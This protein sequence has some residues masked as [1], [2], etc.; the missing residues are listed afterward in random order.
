M[1]P[2]GA[3]KWSAKVSMTM[4]NLQPVLSMVSANV[5]LP[6]ILKPFAN[7]PNVRAATEIAVRSKDIEVR[8]IR[9]DSSKLQV[10]GDLR[11]AP[12]GET[13]LPEAALYP[14]GAILVKLHGLEVGVDLQGSLVRPILGDAQGWYSK[15][16][17]E[18]PAPAKT[19]PEAS[20]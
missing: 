12:S 18:H 19:A 4:S 3:T 16:L 7:V 1:A 20:R 14:W 13:G 11:L 9:V 8:K 2:K 5:P 17:A 6:G 10:D 15:Y